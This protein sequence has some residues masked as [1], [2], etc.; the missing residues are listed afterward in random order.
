M[1]PEEL[2]AFQIKLGLDPDK[3][4]IERKAVESKIALVQGNTKKAKEINREVAKLR[5][6]RNS[7]A[8]YHAKR[9]ELLAR[10]E[11]GLDEEYNERIRKAQEIV[12]KYVE[13]LEASK[14]KVEP[15]EEIWK[16]NEEE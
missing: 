1:T 15:I 5:N 10:R 4:A 3:E 6:R 11:A 14:P 9:K 13:E 12:D 2:R 7:L 16:T 8:R